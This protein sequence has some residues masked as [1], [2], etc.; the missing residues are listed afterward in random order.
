MLT[1]SGARYIM[2]GF[3]HDGG[4]EFGT[5]GWYDI[6]SREIELVGCFA[7]DYRRPVNAIDFTARAERPLE[8]LVTCIFSLGE[9]NEAPRLG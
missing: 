8:K 4:T 6:T 9:A 1:R 3:G 2:P 7:G 5:S